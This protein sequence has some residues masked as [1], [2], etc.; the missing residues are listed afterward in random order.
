MN[1]ATLGN[2]VPGSSRGIQFVPLDCTRCPL[3]AHRTQVVPGE[4]PLHPLAFFV[5]EAP[6]PDED[7]LGRPFIGRAGQIL[8]R[9][10]RDAGWREDD[11]WIT[12]VVKCFPFDMNEDR[13][14]IRA[15]SEDEVAACHDHLANEVRALRPRLIVALGR[16][17][18]ARLLAR[19][20]L[21]LDKLHGT[22]AGAQDGVPVFVTF[23]PSGLHYKKG[24][25]EQFVQ[26]LRRARTLAAE[27]TRT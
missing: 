7:R 17:A 6:G 16:T 18:A 8:R 15:P 9:A 5:G 22:I 21:S 25:N 24:R 19:D 13:K 14:K 2:L 23:H 10:L 3:S 20:D 26:D 12:N 27:A 4:G 1:S 11:V